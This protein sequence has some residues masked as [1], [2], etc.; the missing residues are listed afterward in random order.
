MQVNAISNS[1]T[2]F[3]AKFFN[4]PTMESVVK[5]AVENNKFDKLNASRKRIDLHNITTR[6]IV[7]MGINGKGMPFVSFVRCVPKSGIIIPKTLEDYNLSK[8]IIYASSK[9]I[10]LLKFVTEQL[11]RLGNNAPNNK[12]FRTVVI[13]GGH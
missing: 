11:I 13:K 1:T 10:E 9:K 2:N 6:L 12:M 5:Y 4:T 8:P 7:D 3:K